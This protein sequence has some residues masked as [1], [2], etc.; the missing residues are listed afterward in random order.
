MPDI[1]LGDFGSTKICGQ[2]QAHN[3]VYEK[4]ERSTFF[5]QILIQA[6]GPDYPTESSQY[7]F[8]GMQGLRWL[9]ERISTTSATGTCIDIGCGEGSLSI[10]LHRLCDRKITGYDTS[11]KA[12]EIAKKKNHFNCNFVVADFCHLPIDDDSVAVIS[13]LDCVQHAQSPLLLATELA[14]ISAPGT[15]LIFTHWMRRL[16]PRMLAR[17]DLL[18]SA[19]CAAKFKI[20]E[21]IDLDPNLDIQFRVYA[22]VHANRTLLEEELGSTLLYSLM[23]EAHHLHPRRSKVGHLAVSAVWDP[24]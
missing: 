2:A 15:R 16:D 3:N 11:E 17:Y 14:R 18:C 23:S 19:F 6:M 4:I 9:A 13:A 21:V 10:W 22:Y 7:S 8:V 24:N 12:I 20:E 5:R 1:T